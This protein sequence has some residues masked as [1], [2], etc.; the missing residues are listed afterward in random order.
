[1]GAMGAM[2][3]NTDG[4]S[5]NG[6]LVD[7]LNKT[8]NGLVNLNGEGLLKPKVSAFNSADNLARWDGSIRTK[9][10]VFDLLRHLHFEANAKTGKAEIGHLQLKAGTYN[11]LPIASISRTAKKDHFA[12]FA[13]QLKLVESWA[14]LREE[15]ASEILCQLTPQFPFWNAIIHL[16]LE[17]K[18][19]TV[20]LMMLGLQLC[21]FAE[22]RFKHALCCLR[23]IGYS[24][25][26][27]PM[28]PTPPHGTMPSGHATEAYF[29]AYLLENLL[30]KGKDYRKQ[31]Q[32]LAARI[33]INR[34]VAGLHFPADSQAGQMLGQS[35]AEYFV[36]Q[37]QKN[38]VQP[39]W[40][41]RNIAFA[42]KDKSNDFDPAKLDKGTSKSYKIPAKTEETPIQWLWKRAVAE[43]AII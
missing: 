1:M 43:C 19:K 10:Y 38:S 32:G 17:S 36:A 2:G 22:V 27:Q 31:L 23:P 5:V 29:V 33:A 42:L 25:D 3:A 14:E 30:P 13:A 12:F 41:A 8:R 4:S 11:V 9:V 16:G 24:T 6:M 39:L 18:P 26:L 40:H 37:C 7:A 34:T 21:S 35:L 20:E 15:R 28:I